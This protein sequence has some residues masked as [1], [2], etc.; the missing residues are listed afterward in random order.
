MRAA[1]LGGPEPAELWA[2]T[3]NPTERPRQARLSRTSCVVAVVVA[4]T[5]QRDRDFDCS[6]YDRPAVPGLRGGVH[7]TLTALRLTRVIRGLPGTPG[8][9]RSGAEGV[10]AGVVGLDEGAVLGLGLGLELG[11][12]LVPALGVGLRLELGL[13]LALEI[14]LALELGLLVELGL[15]LEVGLLLALGLELFDGLGLLELPPAQL[16]G[17]VSGWMVMRRVPS[18][19]SSTMGLR[20]GVWL[21]VSPYGKP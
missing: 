4:R 14:G 17:L 15:A 11:L 7:L 13:G 8:R 9:V 10:A 3:L 18:V 16:G 20:S 5:L 2:T 21:N 1:R 12:V 6:S 19:G